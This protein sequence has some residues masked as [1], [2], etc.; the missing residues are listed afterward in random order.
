[1]FLVDDP[2]NE[3]EPAV[4]RLT[5]VELGDI[6][7][8][9]YQVLSGLEAGDRIAISNILKLRDGAPIAPESASTL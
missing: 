9:S 6:Q 8:D 1:M 7:G 5:P 2:S 4:V 3:S